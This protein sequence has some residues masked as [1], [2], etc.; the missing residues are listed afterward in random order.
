M[1]TLIWAEDAL[2]GIGSQ[3]GLPWGR[4]IPADMRWFRRWT[5]GKT[6]AMGRRTWESLPVR[7]LADRRNLVLSRSLAEAPGAELVRKLQ[8]VLACA[9]SEEVF[10]IGGASLFAAC[11]PHASRLLRTRI[12]AEFAADLWFPFAP[13]QEGYACVARETALPGEDSP[14]PLVFE[15]WERRG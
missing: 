12:E 1:L 15:V 7:P 4:P 2:G 6:V 13:E 11:K 14:W 8:A 5:L 9:E 10:V 3:G